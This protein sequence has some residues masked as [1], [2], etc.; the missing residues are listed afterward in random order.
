[1]LEVVEVVMRV[2]R[3]VI[4]HVIWLDEVFGGLDLEDPTRERR[5]AV[6]GWGCIP[7]SGPFVQPIG[8][9]ASV[10]ISFRGGFAVIR[11]AVMM[12]SPWRGMRSLSSPGGERDRDRDRC[13][14]GVRPHNCRFHVVV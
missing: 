12:P 3:S 2:G 10:T 1:M 6:N 7:A 14:G 5:M 13:L 4:L 11:A 8:P 9:S